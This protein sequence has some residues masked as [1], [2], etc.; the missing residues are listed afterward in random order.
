MMFDDY[1]YFTYILEWTKITVTHGLFLSLLALGVKT[2]SVSVG[3][4]VKFR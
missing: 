1:R 2:S 3:K 4:Q